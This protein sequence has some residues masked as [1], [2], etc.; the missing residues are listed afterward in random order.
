[1]CKI[2]TPVRNK[3]VVYHKGY[4]DDAEFSFNK[5]GVIVDHIPVLEE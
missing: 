4:R 3:R 1:V 2:N 5:A